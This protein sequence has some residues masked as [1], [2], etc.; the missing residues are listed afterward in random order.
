MMLPWLCSK[1][2]RVK[3]GERAEIRR[4]LRL[5]EKAILLW[6]RLMEEMIKFGIL[7]VQCGVRIEGYTVALCFPVGFRPGMIRTTVWT[8]M[9]RGDMT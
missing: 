4:T 3:R 2:R 1:V 8:R 9:W 6:A 5:C 7:W